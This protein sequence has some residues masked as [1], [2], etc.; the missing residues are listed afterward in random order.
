MVVIV[1]RLA[2]TRTPRFTTLSGLIIT[3]QSGYQLPRQLIRLITTLVVVVAM[4]AM[5]ATPHHPPL[6]TLA[7]LPARLPARLLARRITRV[8]LFRKAS[9]QLAV[10]ARTFLAFVPSATKA[11]FTGKMRQQLC[12][13]ARTPPSTGMATSA[14]R[15]RTDQSAKQAALRSA[16]CLTHWPT[17]TR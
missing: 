12:I 10:C 9:P 3:S 7:Q 13:G 17:P 2:R 15:T 8:I 14:G 11:T 1:R 5:V 16:T 4:V 6:P